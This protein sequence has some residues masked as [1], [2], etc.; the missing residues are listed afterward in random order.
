VAVGTDNIRDPF[1]PYLGC[2]LLLNAILTAITCHMVTTADFELVVELHTFSPAAV[3]GL[4]RYGLAVGC[5]ADLVV[6]EARSIGELLD[7]YRLPL[8]VFKRGRLVAR[9]DIVREYSPDGLK[10]TL[11]TCDA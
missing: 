8:L 6:L 2:D 9:N 11:T 10:P 3:M 5:D 1:N 7:G 4:A